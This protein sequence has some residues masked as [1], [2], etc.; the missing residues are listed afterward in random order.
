M[1]K[2]SKRSQQEV[3]KEEELNPIYYEAPTSNVVDFMSLLKKSIEL[4]EKKHKKEK[5]A[6]EKARDIERQEVKKQERK[7]EILQEELKKKKV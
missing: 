6:A 2:Y 4:S 3:K 1:T 5:E 7:K